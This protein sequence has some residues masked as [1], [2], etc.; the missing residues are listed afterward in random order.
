MKSELFELE[1]GKTA[2]GSESDDEGESFAQDPAKMGLVGLG[3]LLLVPLAVYFVDRRNGDEEDWEDYE[4]EVRDEPIRTASFQEDHPE[5][6]YDEEAYD[7]DYSDSD[8]SDSW[9]KRFK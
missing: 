3:I 4:D 7:E 8:Y 2:P 1:F 6:L 9:D 5:M